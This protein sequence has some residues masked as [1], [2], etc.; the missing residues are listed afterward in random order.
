MHVHCAPI[1]GK[2]GLRR[3]I[4]GKCLRIG[5]KLRKPR[6]GFPRISLHIPDFTFTEAFGVTEVPLYL[7]PALAFTI[8]KEA[9]YC[10]CTDITLQGRRKYQRAYLCGLW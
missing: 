10:E 9:L 6:P 5:G 2:S 7:N 1:P 4:P 3:K 8:Y